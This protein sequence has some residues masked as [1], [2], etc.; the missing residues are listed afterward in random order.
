[1]DSLDV[2]GRCTVGSTAAAASLGLDTPSAFPKD[3]AEPRV[4]LG[5]PAGDGLQR[6][7]SWSRPFACRSKSRV[8]SVDPA[9]H[10]FQTGAASNGAHRLK[11][12][13]L[14]ALT[15]ATAA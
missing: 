1:L 8:W 13:R 6:H 5:E 14:R 3:R 9:V 4:V 11:G 15:T 12:R 7:E 2:I 10:D